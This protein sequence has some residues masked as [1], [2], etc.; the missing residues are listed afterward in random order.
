M[1]GFLDAM[2]RSS[3]A[4]VAAASARESLPA[5]RARALETPLPAPLRLDDSFSLIAEYK[6]HSPSQGDLS[7]N[8]RLLE[9]VTAY[10]RAGASAISVLTEPTQFHGNLEDLAAA[11]AALAPLDV[12][13]LRKDFLIDPYQL[14]E[15]RASG[16][17]GVLLIVRILSDTQ[18]REMLDCANDLRLFLLMEAFDAEDISRAARVVAGRGPERANVCSSERARDAPPEP[19]ARGAPILLGLNCRNLDTL[20]V[21]R[22]RFSQLASLLPG[23][24]PRVAESGITTPDDCADV[25]RCGYDVALVGS[26]LMRAPDP[27]AMIRTMLA[28]ARAASRAAA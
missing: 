5:L 19:A 20:E 14:C 21:S 11:A 8:D 24:M 12:P 23:N 28:A 17:G 18:L 22:Q 26:A 7:R 13:V 3:R 1:S 9:Q 6:R 16:A 4:R 10:A 25:A 27:A 15:S 2:I